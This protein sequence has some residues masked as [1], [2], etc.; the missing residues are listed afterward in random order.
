MVEIDTREAFSADDGLA[1]LEYLNQLGA[2]QIIYLSLPLG[3]DKRFYQQA[4]HSGN[5]IVGKTPESILRSRHT[6]VSPR[7]SAMQPAG[8]AFLA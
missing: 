6:E 3:A 4:L 1:V 2:S 8:P 5:V 7:E